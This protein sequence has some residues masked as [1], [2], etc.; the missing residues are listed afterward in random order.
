MKLIRLFAAALLTF[1][2]TAC[3]SAYYDA[4]ERR[5]VEKRDIL[6]ERIIEARA[7][8][9]ETQIVFTNALDQFRS[10]ID[11][12][13]GGLEHKYDAMKISL[14]QSQKQAEAV[15]NRINAVNAVG[16]RLF[17]EWE[18]ELNLYESADLRKRSREQLVTARSEYD[19]LM[20]A[21]ENAAAKMAPVISIYS[22]QV[23]FLKH[24]L[25]ARAVSSLEVE[26][27]EI[28][29]RVN[30]LVDEM[31]AAIAQADTFIATME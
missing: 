27:D 19:A 29:T 30:A 31:N 24:N 6:V 13:A 9:A 15:R 8:Q 2:L 21:M 7:A 14:N 10:L 4:M 25:N 20:R 17:K 11:V 16:R 22:D 1:T 28:E 12:E 26:R 5:G 3:A 23:L 18:G